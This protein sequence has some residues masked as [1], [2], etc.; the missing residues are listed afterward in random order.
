METSLHFV[1]EKARQLLL[2]FKP[3]IFLSQSISFSL[4][5]SLS[6][7]IHPTTPTPVVSSRSLSGP[8][9]TPFLLSGI[10]IT[11]L[12]PLTFGSVQVTVNFT[13][14]FGTLTGQWSNAAKYKVEFNAVFRYG[15]HA[16]VKTSDWGWGA[17]IINIGNFVS[18]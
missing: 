8:E 18:Y 2:I 1:Y 6:L 11:T 16:C 10:T 7:V 9:D 13:T 15:V 14:R 17:M 4:L 3:I 12:D 5:L